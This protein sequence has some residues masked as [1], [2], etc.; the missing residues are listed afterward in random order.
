MYYTYNVVSP[1]LRM[2]GIFDSPFDLVLLLKV[3]REIVGVGVIDLCKSLGGSC[4]KRLMVLLI[5]GAR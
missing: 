5:T 1:R 2:N 4:T 3:A